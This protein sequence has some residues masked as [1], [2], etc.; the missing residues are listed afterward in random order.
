MLLLAIFFGSAF[1]DGTAQT[2]VSYLPPA[3]AL[4]MPQRILEGNAAWWEPVVALV[5]LLAAASAVILA[6]ERLYRRSLL[7]TQGRLSLRQAWS[8]PE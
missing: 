8:T 4:L 7:Q 2:V 6:A 1:L 3:S 5:I